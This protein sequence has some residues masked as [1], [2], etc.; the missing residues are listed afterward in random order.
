MEALHDDVHRAVRHL[1]EIVHAG[2]VRM[3]DVH[4]DVRLAT[5][6]RDLAA[7]LRGRA[8][9]H[10][11][12][13]LV[14]ERGVLG[15]VDDAD[16][17]RADLLADAVFPAEDG[18]GELAGDGAVLVASPFRSRPRSSA[19]MRFFSNA[20][21]APSRLPRSHMR[22]MPAPSAPR[23]R[24]RRARPRRARRERRRRAPQTT[25][26]PQ[27]AA[28]PSRSSSRGDPT[29]R[30]RC[31]TSSP[32]ARHVSC[33]TRASGKPQIRGMPA[34]LAFARR[35]EEHLGRDVDLL[36]LVVAVGARPI[37]EADGADASTCRPWL[38]LALDVA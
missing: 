2:D 24:P 20:R 21:D 23:E 26:A 9:Q 29:R 4:L 3:I 25:A 35:A 31:T 14:A 22:A 10:L 16:A 18:A 36:G 32:F 37:H 28:A 12:G 11:H 19:A 34:E 6:A 1:I 15:G 8:A 38:V 17:A 5:E 27:T 33:V 7:V 13:D 30:G